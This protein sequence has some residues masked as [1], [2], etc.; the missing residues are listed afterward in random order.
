MIQCMKKAVRVVSFVDDCVTMGEIK[1]GT[2]GWFTVIIVD[3]I[4]DLAPL[5]PLTQGNPAPVAD[6][7]GGHE[8]AVISYAQKREL[9]WM[10]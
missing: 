3:G 8:V 5:A 9:N 2:C 10:M 6:T 4:L 1:N 7:V